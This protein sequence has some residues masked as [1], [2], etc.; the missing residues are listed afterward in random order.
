[1]RSANVNS[2]SEVVQYFTLFRTGDDADLGRKNDGQSSAFSNR[3]F[4][5]GRLCVLWRVNLA[6]GLFVQIG[7]GRDAHSSSVRVR[8]QRFGT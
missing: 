4:D 5:G 8:C 7:C 2:C 6:I 3:M 1:M